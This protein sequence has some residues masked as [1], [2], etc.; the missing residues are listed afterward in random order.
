MLTGLSPRN[1]KGVPDGAL[2]PLLESLLEVDSEKRP[3]PRLAA[4]DT[5]RSIGVPGG[6]PWQQDPEPPEVF[7]RD[8]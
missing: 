5:L 2:K 3:E 8:L 1:Q 7:P 4:L 6:A